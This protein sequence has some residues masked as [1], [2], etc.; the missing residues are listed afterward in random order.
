MT[1][2]TG[3]RV[4]LNELA[5]A[6][7]AHCPESFN[8]WGKKDW[9]THLQA[10]RG[11]HIYQ[12]YWADLD[13]YAAR[14]RESLLPPL[15]F[16][17]FR[18]FN[19]SGERKA[20]EDVYF[21]RRGR[22][23]A[24]AL[25]AGADPS[26]ENIQLL[27]DLLWD[28]CDEY[29]WCLPAHLPANDDSL[30][31]R[32]NVDLFAAETA[33]MLAEIIT[34]HKRDIDTRITERVRK[35]IKLRIFEPVFWNR[36][37]FHW[38]SADHNWSAVCAGG[39]GIA[40]LLL[41]EDSMQLTSAITRVI[42]SMD[43]FLS[44]YGLDGG[45]AEGLGYWVYGFGYYNY[46]AEMLKEYTSGCI[47]ILDCP[48]SEAISSFPENVH[49]SGGVFVNYSDCNESE[50][51]PPGLLTR[52]AERSH[53][54]TS[55][56]FVMPLISDDSCH[57]WAHLSRNVLWSNPQVFGSQRQK[58][59]VYLLDLNWLIHRGKIH[60]QD[61]KPIVVSFST[62]GGHND[63]PHNH[64]DLGH[65]LLHGGGE[66]LLCD[67]GP[68]L[69]TKSYFSSGREKI[70]NIS[71][72]GHS[73]P[74]I[75]GTL[76][77]SGR[78]AEAII[79]EGCLSQTGATQTLDLTSAY[80]NAGIE[81]LVRHFNWSLVPEANTASLILEDRIVWNDTSGT[82]EERLISKFPPHIEDG[83]IIWYG[84]HAEL[85]LDYNE[86]YMKAISTAIPHE[87]HDG[88]PFTFYQT[89]LMIHPSP[90]TETNLTVCRLSFF[91]AS[92]HNN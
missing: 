41:M 46:F 67:L 29:T 75:N 33:G 37:G 80:P 78:S 77:C 91:I 63:E 30:S 68:G 39:C 66:N 58:E 73:L 50:L 85:T 61:G 10:T 8:P 42:S 15:T 12:K 19:D 40:A 56:P 70:S 20:Y 38:E 72:G 62:K 2:D 27:E 74:V 87:D 13:S 18:Q 7:V 43:A 32:K 60:D 34:M 31:L 23:A 1:S 6:I 71:S 48:K 52:L 76:Q 24:L 45:C 22:I 25:V 53:R 16:S 81:Q 14:A 9:R 5:N 21:E 3:I 4:K 54:H 92:Y 28:I 51:L 35:E 64:N 11:S 69:Y 26:H 59:N 44:G 88:V 57:R 83:R 36:V 17:L 47:D 82:I 90:D 49:L 89:S 84:R 65:F 55:L 79:L 86:D